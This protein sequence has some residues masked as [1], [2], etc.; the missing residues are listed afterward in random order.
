MDKN[1]QLKAAN[2]RYKPI[3]IVPN[4]IQM[5]CCSL[6]KCKTAMGDE[7]EDYDNEDEDDKDNVSLNSTLNIVSSTAVARS[8]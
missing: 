5:Q 2:R 4:E 1:L 3:D 6:Q 7:E 8:S